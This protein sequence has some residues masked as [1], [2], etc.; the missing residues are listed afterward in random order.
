MQSVIKVLIM[1]RYSKL[2]KKMKAINII[3]A[4]LAFVMFYSLSLS[5]QNKHITFIGDIYYVSMKGHEGK[6]PDAIYKNEKG[7]H[8]LIIINDKKAVFYKDKRSVAEYNNDSLNE[9]KYLFYDVELF[10]KKKKS[11]RNLNITYFVESDSV[12][13]DKTS[14]KKWDKITP[15]KKPKLSE[16]TIAWY[17]YLESQ[18]ISTEFIPPEIVYS[19]ETKQINGFN[20]KK[21]F[22]ALGQRKYTVWFSED[23]KYNWC[24][25]DFRYLIP[26]TVILMEYDE[27]PYLEFVSIEDLDYNN[28]SLNKKILDVVLKNW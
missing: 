13:I 3:I 20:C 25:Q 1:I 22:V 5:A 8:N 18:G 4:F 9:Y 26:G 11:S 21:A 6:T 7:V 28:L 24:F 10:D 17:E 19:E 14:D 23:I 27:K 12:K 16:K 2:Q 15:D